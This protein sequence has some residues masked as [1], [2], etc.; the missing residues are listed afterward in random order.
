MGADSADL[1]CVGLFLLSLVCQ[2]S[3]KF[4]TYTDFICIVAEAETEPPIITTFL[5]LD[6][7]L[8]K[9][10]CALAGNEVDFVFSG[11]VIEADLTDVLHT[12]SI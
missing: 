10:N 2:V 8:H 9:V 7:Q 12:E 11:I 3:S 4:V 5:Q 1:G 6:K